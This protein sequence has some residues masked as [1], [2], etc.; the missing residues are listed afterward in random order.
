MFPPSLQPPA[1]PDGLR[2]HLC[3][4]FLPQRDPEKTCALMRTHKETK[5]S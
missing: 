3:G 4:P 5:P 2:S 1:A